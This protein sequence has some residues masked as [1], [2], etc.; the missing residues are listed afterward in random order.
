MTMREFKRY[1]NNTISGLE[2]IIR[3]YQKANKT[4][5]TD[6]I[7][8]VAKLEELKDIRKVIDLWFTKQS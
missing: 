7:K 4:Y 5:G 8:R 6:Y 3:A 2:T 1:I